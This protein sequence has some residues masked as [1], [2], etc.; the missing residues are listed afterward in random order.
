MKTVIIILGAARSGSTL[1]AKAIGG[2]SACFGLGEINRF[3]EEIENPDTHCGCGEKLNLCSFWS[4]I[5]QE[6]NLDFTSTTRQSDN[7]NVGI[8]NQLTKKKYLHKLINTVVFKSVYTN[9]L[10]EREIE[11][12]F[13]LYNKIFEKTNV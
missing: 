12:T 13:T 5:L 2:H 3:N 9:K 11:N 7:F 1:L 6:L 8:F 10:V 4:Q